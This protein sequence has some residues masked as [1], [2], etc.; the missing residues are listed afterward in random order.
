MTP[1]SIKKYEIMQ[2]TAFNA[3]LTRRI[4]IKRCKY[5]ENT[6]ARIF[7]ECTLRFGFKAFIKKAFRTLMSEICLCIRNALAAPKTIKIKILRIKYFI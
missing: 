7:S 4:S 2:S 5:Y 6:F 1:S 3:I